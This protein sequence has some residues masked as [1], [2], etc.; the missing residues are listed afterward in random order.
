MD[1]KVALEKLFADKTVTLKDQ[2]KVKLHRV[3]LETF[4]PALE[5]LHKI[6]DHL[7]LDVAK[8]IDVGALAENPIGILKLISKFYGEAL[9]LAAS[10]TSLELDEVKA[11]E[12]DDGIKLLHGV[13]VVNLD[14]FTNEV[15]PTLKATGLGPK[16]SN[17]AA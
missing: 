17:A 14:F 3:S 13:Y 11:L 15:I 4:G 9:V 10:L 1:T 12:A 6:V 5:L 8:G 16:Q 2:R 7:G